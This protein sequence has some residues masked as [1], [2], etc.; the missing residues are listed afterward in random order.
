MLHILVG[1]VVGAIV[2]GVATV[3]VSAVTGRPITFN[4][5][6]AGV[7]GGAVGGAVT[8][9]TF[10]AGG[11]AAATTARA[12]S[13]FVLGGS[14]GGATAQA[15]ENVLEGRPIAEGVPEATVIGGALGA[16]TFGAG[17]ALGPVARRVIDRVRPG[18][19]GAPGGA[20]A[21]PAAPNGG[22]AGSG[23][24]GG[25]RGFDQILDDV[26]NSGP[27]DDVAPPTRR[28]ESLGEMLDDMRTPSRPTAP[29]PTATTASNGSTPPA[30]QND[31]FVDALL[32]DLNGNA[33]GRANASRGELLEELAE[34]GVRH[35]PDNVVDVRRL[36]DGR[37]AFLESGNA[38]AGLRHIVERHADD[39][40]ARGVPEER[41]PDLV[42]D[43]ISRGRVVGHQ[44]RGNGR[45]IFEVMFDGQVQRVAVTVGDNGFVVGANPASVR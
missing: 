8:T 42:M 20:R 41:I 4:S 17:K 13:A 11:V 40:A 19:G 23:S 14:T 28:T 3:A 31:G 9:A 6:A 5:I 36:A 7:V 45:P 2:G 32:D 21:P 30:R 44:G 35:T 26:R 1:G 10:G 39:F 43:A 18:R 16:G 37:I 15:T 25:R 33:G 34:N 29:E 22:G 12:A 27:A 24:S 38:R